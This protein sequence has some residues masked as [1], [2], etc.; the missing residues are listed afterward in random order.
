MNEQLLEVL[1]RQAQILDDLA[2]LYG[3][4]EHVLKGDNHEYVAL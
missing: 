2:R 3:R 4:I 1:E